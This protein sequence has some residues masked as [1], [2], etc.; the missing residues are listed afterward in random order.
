LITR[1]SNPP[2]RMLGDLA[3][4][5]CPTLV[6]GGEED[7]MTPI[8]CQADIVAA[9][10]PHLVEFVRFRACGHAV[11]PDAPEAAWQKCASSYMRS[12]RPRQRLG[13][14]TILAAP[15]LSQGPRRRETLAVPGVLRAG[16]SL[17][18]GNC[19]G[20]AWRHRCAQRV[21][22]MKSV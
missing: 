6:M 20:A 12:L 9:L 15:A 3:R 14:A 16:K 1:S 17:R 22:T 19:G 10:P 8:E 5:E 11:V 2:T 7:P 18:I 4:V 13:G 21:S